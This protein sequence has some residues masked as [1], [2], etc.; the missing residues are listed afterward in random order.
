[1]ERMSGGCCKGSHYHEAVVTRVDRRGDVA[2]LYLD[3]SLETVPGQ[4]VMVWLPG[5]EEVPM[6]PSDDDPLRI[7][8]KAVGKTTRRLVG[9]EPGDRLYIRGPYGR[10]FTRRS[11]RPLLVGGGVGAAPL[12]LLAKK[13][14]E[15]GVEGVYVEGQ[16]SGDVE[17]FIRE[18]LDLGWEA[19]LY[20]EDGSRGYKGL[21]TQYLE[22]N[23][24]G[25]T[26]IYACGPEPMNRAVLRLCGDRIPCEVSMERIVKCGVG[27]CGSCVVEGTGLLVCLDGP[28][29]RADE[30]LGRGYPGG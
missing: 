24:G 6:A 25:F 8:V 12:I 20:T 21:P 30:L 5:L 13:L 3:I 7:T 18:A 9:M 2:N 17:L 11:G 26:S 27:V 14:A 23:L 10:G 28:V 29:F 15:M 4:F 16:P 22:E 19:I 1:M